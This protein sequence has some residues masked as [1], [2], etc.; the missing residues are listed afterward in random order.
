M[1][2]A[3]ANLSPAYF[4]LAMATGIVSIA[5][6]MHG[7]FFIALPLFWMNVGFY[8]CLWGLYVIRLIA[9]PAKMLADLSDHKNGVG[10]LTMAAGTGIL[11]NQCILLYDASLW[12]LVLFF[13]ALAL[14]LFFMYTLLT[15]FTIKQ[16]KP[17]LRSS[18]HGGWLLA[19]VSTQSLSILSG[20]LVNGYPSHQN[21]LFFSLL[22][23]FLGCLLDL[24][25]IPLIFYRLMF[26]PMEPEE[27]LPTDWII[28]GADAITTLAGAS[29]VAQMRHLGVWRHQVM[30]VEGLTL[31]FWITASWWIP[32]LGLL[33]LWKHVV[34]RI[35]IVYKPLYW[36]MVFP[37]GMYAA[38]SAHAG[39]IFEIDFMI[40]ISTIFVLIALVSW[41]F[42]IWG[43]IRAA[44]RAVSDG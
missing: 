20:L 22:M 33:F 19:T 18:I 38:C 30:V 4:A 37:L 28:M 27:F 9:F 13:I 25:I 32:L 40:T 31:F 6:H 26:L 29:L 11:G 3:I 41:G 42:S 14:W 16:L 23:L 36:G 44:A 35:R 8:V 2:A 1:K 7:Y 21:L 5:A 15:S 34:R 39:K 12:A 43:M 24:M 17:F 10:Y